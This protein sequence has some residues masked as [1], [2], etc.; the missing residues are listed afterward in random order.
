M[1]VLAYFFNIISHPTVIMAAFVIFFNIIIGHAENQVFCGFFL[2]GGQIGPACIPEKPD[3][4]AMKPRVWL[5]GWLRNWPTQKLSARIR[6]IS[7][8]SKSIFPQN[9]QY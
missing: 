9:T 7:V 8:A 1:S 2:G 3:F 5:R 4:G 6:K